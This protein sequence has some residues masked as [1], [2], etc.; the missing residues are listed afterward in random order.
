[1]R[2][3]SSDRPGAG[4]SIVRWLDSWAVDG[5][6]ADRDP[7]EIDWLRIVPFLVLHASCLLV[8]VVGWSWTALAVAVR[9][10]LWSGCYEG[11][12]FSKENLQELQGRTP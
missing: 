12:C 5:R 6:D 11:S 10:P 2:G 4:A 1:M 7:R 9:H 8:F 3:A